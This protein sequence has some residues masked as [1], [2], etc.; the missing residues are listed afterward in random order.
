MRTDGCKS[1]EMG[2]ICT[3]LRVANPFSESVVTRGIIEFSPISFWDLQEST[4][5]RGLKKQI[6]DLS[7]CYHQNVSTSCQIHPLVRDSSFVQGMRVRPCPSSLSR[8][9][10]NA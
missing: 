3:I 5:G 9:W 4:P 10:D 8:S 2:R 7:S 6:T 1:H